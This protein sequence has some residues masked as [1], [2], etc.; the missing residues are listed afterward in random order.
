MYAR[1]Q[2]IP[3]LMR[4][5]CTYSSWVSCR[6]SQ[7]RI[8]FAVLVSHVSSTWR[9]LA[10]SCSSLWADITIT[11]DNMHKVDGELAIVNAS[12]LRAKEFASRSRVFSLFVRLKLFTTP[13]LDF[14]YFRLG[15]IM[16]MNWLRLVLPR[17]K[18]LS[19][20]CDTL[21]VAWLV[22]KCLHTAPMET[23]ETCKMKYGTTILSFCHSIIPPPVRFLFLAGQNEEQ[24]ADNFFPKLTRV[25]ASGFPVSW[26]QWSLTRLTSLSINFMT[27]H[28]RPLMDVLKYILTINRETLEKFEIQGAI[29]Q[30]GTLLRNANELPTNLPRLADLT[31]GYLSQWEAIIFFLHFETPALKHLKLCDISRSILA[32]H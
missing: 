6:N 16:T 19:I 4:S 1:V 20:H 27:L 14:E 32:Q 18:Y 11:A 9:N 28:D 29:R 23:L 5:F 7:K 2:L 12:L 22:T 3:C 26:S 30:F 21:Q 10:F 17:V 13:N 25:K 15:T 24:A 8:D 31:L